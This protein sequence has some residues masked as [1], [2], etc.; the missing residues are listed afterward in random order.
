MLGILALLQPIDATLT[1]L[2]LQLLVALVRELVLAR[3]DEDLLVLPIAGFGL[4]PP[5]DPGAGAVG[6]AE[7]VR[8]EDQ[9][10]RPACKARHRL[11]ARRQTPFHL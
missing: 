4:A 5:R 1:E 8:G 7:G 9:V 11:T 6:V 2:A 10:L 3:G